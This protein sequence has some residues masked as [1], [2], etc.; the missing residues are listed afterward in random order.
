MM[1][2]ERKKGLQHQTDPELPEVPI[3]SKIM[4]IEKEENVMLVS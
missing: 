3:V 4:H 1:Y 2:L